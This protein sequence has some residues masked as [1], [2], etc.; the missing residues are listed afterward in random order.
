MRKVNKNP[1]ELRNSST[2]RRPESPQHIRGSDVQQSHAPTRALVP[3]LFKQRVWL[4]NPRHTHK[5]AQN[6]TTTT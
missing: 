1:T 2:D 3:E 6:P 4:D 5:H